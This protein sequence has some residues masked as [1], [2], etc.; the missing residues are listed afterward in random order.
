M[1]ANINHI[2]L[3][4]QQKK[5]FINNISY[6]QEKILICDNCNDSFASS[7]FIVDQDT[8]IMTDHTFFL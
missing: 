6:S 7:E 4:H 2:L 5:I 8:S 1:I 3:N